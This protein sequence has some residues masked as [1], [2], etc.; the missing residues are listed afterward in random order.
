MD[1]NEVTHLFPYL[2]EVWDP[3]INKTG[4]WEGGNLDLQ[5]AGDPHS[6]GPWAVAGIGELGAEG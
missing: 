1:L 2:R 4:Q 5:V 3:W 6:L